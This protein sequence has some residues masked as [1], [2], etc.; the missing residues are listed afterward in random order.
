MVTAETVQHPDDINP[1]QPR[2]SVYRWDERVKQYRNV[3]TGKFVKRQEVRAAL[4]KMLDEAKEDAISLARDLQEGNITTSRW[5]AE[6]R[7]LMRN[8][9]TAAGASAKGGWAQMTPSD[10][11]FIGSELKREYQFLQNFAEQVSNEDI[12]LDGRFVTRAGLYG[13]SARTTYH[14]VEKRDM[15]NSGFTEERSI[16]DPAANHCSECLDMADRGWV[17]VNTLIPIGARI[18]LGKCKCTMIY[19]NPETGETI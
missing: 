19:R 15:F 13:E 11:G 18:C 12:P 4:D 5:Q 6:M 16:L 8:V 3:Q 7:D 2:G 17:P 9:H 10:W 1:V 14:E